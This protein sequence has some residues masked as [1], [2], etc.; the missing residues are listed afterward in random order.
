MSAGMIRDDRIQ[1][2]RLKLILPLLALL[3][4][5]GVKSDALL[6]T[7]GL[8]R[9]VVEQSDIFIAAARMYT[10]FEGIAEASGDACFGV[11]AGERFDLEN[12]PPFA[13]GIRR[14]SSLGDLLVQISLDAQNEATS[15]DFVATVTGENTTFS[16][17]RRA[18]PNL[19]PRHNDAFIMA[20]LLRILQAATGAENLGNTVLAKVCDP[21]VIPEGYLGIRL[22]ACDTSGVSITF[23]SEWLRMHVRPT[24]GSEPGD[25]ASTERQPPQTTLDTI[26]HVLRQHLGD[27]DLNSEQ[28]AK[29]L[30]TSR[31]TLSRRLKKMNTSLA[32]EIARQRR[33]IAEQELLRGELSVAAIGARIGYP[34]PA[35]FSRAFKRWTGQTPSHYRRNLERA[36]K[37]P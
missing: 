33:E 12:W 20:Y 9:P 23:P 15:A 14:A 16:E 31:R 21:A 24:A 25:M 6:E 18:L 13:N 17:R 36:R 30:G 27:S 34:D 32:R 37:S 26:H 8:T 35:V 11:H 19:T 2:V 7:H 4:E 10:L 3:E 29:L 22:A 5:K 28:V 1:L